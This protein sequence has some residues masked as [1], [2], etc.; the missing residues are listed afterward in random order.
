MDLII[1]SEEEKEEEEE[2]F[3]ERNT[4]LYEATGSGWEL[5]ST[6]SES[7]PINQHATIGVST[8]LEFTQLKEGTE[9]KELIVHKFDGYQKTF[10]FIAGEWKE[11][12][13]NIPPKLSSTSERENF[14]ITDLNKD[15]IDDLVFL[16]AA[17]TSAG[18]Q[19][20]INT[21]TSWVASEDKR[22]PPVYLAQ[23]K[24]FEQHN[25]FVDLNGDGLLDLINHEKI[26]SSSLLLLH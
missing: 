8:F 26:S 18:L 21:G 12:K 16:N 14:K 10:Q 13:F 23:W 17:T 25:L 7:F 2:I 11:I 6:P 5:K 4:F 22:V 15:G 19:V 20:F 1:F 3:T 9:Y 24:K